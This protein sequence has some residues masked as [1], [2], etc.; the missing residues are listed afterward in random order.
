MTI[1]ELATETELGKNIIISCI[2][3]ANVGRKQGAYNYDAAMNAIST[4]GPGRNE[5]CGSELERAAHTS[6]EIRAQAESRGI[7]SR[8]RML[9]NIPIYAETE[10]G[11][12]SKYVTERNA[13]IK[14]ESRAFYRQRAKAN[15]EKH[16]TALSR[17]VQAEKRRIANVKI[18][19]LA[20]KG[21]TIETPKT[22]EEARVKDLYERRKAAKKKYNQAHSAKLKAAGIKQ[23]N[24]HKK[25][26]PEE[27][28]NA[29]PPGY[30]KVSEVAKRFDK[31]LSTVTRRFDRNPDLI[32]TKNGYRYVRIED[33]E[34]LMEAIR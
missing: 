10:V 25:K 17:E 3:S 32:L 27:R 26:A 29:S 2:K 28:K 11:K 16:G 24:N 19:E 34:K 5:L 7:I 14:K 23:K 20:K 31:A 18:R 33:V 8:L 9:G 21:R 30:L 1:A 13:L 12:L 4:F 22:P 6:I 15:S